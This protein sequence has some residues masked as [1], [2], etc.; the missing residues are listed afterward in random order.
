MAK[1]ESDSNLSS[2]IDSKSGKGLPIISCLLSLVIPTDVY[3]HVAKLPLG[4]LWLAG[5]VSLAELYLRYFFRLDFKNWKVCFKPTSALRCC[6]GQEN[7][8]TPNS[9]PS[10]P[11]P[12]EDDAFATNATRACSS[13]SSGCDAS[14]PVTRKTEHFLLAAILGQAMWSAAIDS[15]FGGGFDQP[16]RKAKLC[17]L[18]RILAKVIFFVAHHTLHLNSIYLFG[19]HH[20][21]DDSHLF[22]CP[23]SSLSSNRAVICSLTPRLPSREKLVPKPGLPSMTTTLEFNQGFQRAVLRTNV[24]SL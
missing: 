3:E 16:S 11:R 7:G 12:R 5:A 1:G 9:T 6:V 22:I 8:G 20:L 18:P 2:E 10:R 17:W 4:L 19:S 23:L 15:A 21:I 13:V 24:L 14:R